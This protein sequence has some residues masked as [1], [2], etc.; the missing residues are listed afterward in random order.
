[1]CCLVV[2]YKNWERKMSL[3]FLAKSA[4]LM[5]FLLAAGIFL[6]NMASAEA[7][8]SVSL[9]SNGTS[10]AQSFI[11]GEP[12]VLNGSVDFYTTDVSS[13]QVALTI[14]GPV[15]VTQALPAVDGLYT[16][17]SK[18]LTVKVTS[19]TT[20]FANG[21]TLGSTVGTVGTVGS[22]LSTLGTLSSGS[23]CECT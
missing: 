21:G 18:Y 20:T 1:M 6:R 10:T 15:P 14:N 22:T 19:T 16:Y 11:L 8:L 23:S 7:P 2:F 17:A 13:A 9:T 5:V 3:K 12:I 4:V